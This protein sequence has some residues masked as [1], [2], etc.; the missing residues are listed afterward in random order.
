VLRVRKIVYELPPEAPPGGHSYTAAARKLYRRTVAHEPLVGWAGGFFCKLT[1]GGGVSQHAV[2]T[3][4][5]PSAGNAFDWTAPE[6]VEAQGAQAIIDWLW[7]L[8]RWQVA[9]AKAGELPLSE[10]IFRDRKWRE[11]SGRWGAYTG[12]LHAAHI[13]SSASPYVD[14]AAACATA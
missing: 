2:R 6:H 8:A 3:A 5:F 12:Q 14:R 11:S 4:Q 1:V 10:N 13:H 9:Q 7:V